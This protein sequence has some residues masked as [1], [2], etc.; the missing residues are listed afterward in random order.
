MDISKCDLCKMSKRRAMVPYG[1]MHNVLAINRGDLLAIDIFGP[2]PIGRYG[3]EKII[4]VLDVFTR[5]VRLY[6]MKKADTKS[7][8]RALEKYITEFG[9]P[10]V[11]LSDNGSNSTSYAWKAHWRHRQIN[12]RYT[13]VYLSLIHISEPTRPY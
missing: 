4:V 2:L 9:L 6:P 11:I 3:L 12:L 1:E 10:G 7:S 5:F 13:S 8:I